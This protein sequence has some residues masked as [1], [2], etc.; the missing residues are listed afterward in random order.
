[1]CHLSTPKL[2]T[3]SG[4]SQVGKEKLPLAVHH[5][6][7]TDNARARCAIVVVVI[8]DRRTQLLSIRRGITTRN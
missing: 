6:M 8:G 5:D 3:T 7:E 2:D 1:M 4:L